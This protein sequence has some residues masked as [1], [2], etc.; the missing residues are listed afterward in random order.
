MPED[1]PRPSIFFQIFSEKHWS[2][3]LP[4]P[5]FD[6]SVFWIK[7]LLCHGGSI[8][9][10]IFLLVF[11]VLTTLNYPQAVQRI[12]TASLKPAQ[13]LVSVIVVMSWK[14]Q[15]YFKSFWF[16]QFWTSHSVSFS[17]ELFLVELFLNNWNYYS[18][19]IYKL[20]FWFLIKNS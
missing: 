14:P 8:R 17:N 5:S 12:H 4:S 15:F 6:R 16:Y 3:N 1:L 10:W 13:K 2:T 11:C 20:W 19:V 7:R 9:S 18:V